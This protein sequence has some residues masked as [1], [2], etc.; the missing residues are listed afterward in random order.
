MNPE[1]FSTQVVGIF[2]DAQSLAIRY[3]NAEITDLHLTLAILRTNGLPLFDILLELGVDLKEYEDKIIE[4]IKKLRSSKG[5]TKL[6]YSRSYQRIIINSEEISRNLYESFVNVNS[7]YLA[8][9]REDKTVSQSIANSFSIDYEK[10]RSIFVEEFTKEKAGAISLENMKY[11]LKFGR[12]LTKEASEGKI[13]PIIGRDEETTNVIRVLSRRIKNNPV[14]IGEAGVGKTAVVEGLVKRIASKDVPEALRDKIVFSLDMTSI[15]AGAKFR[16]DFEERLKKVLDIVKASNTKIIL[17]IDEIHNI[18]GSGTSGAMDTSNIL[19][20]ML[21]RGEILTIGATTTRE[22]RKYIETD[23]A[24]ERRFQKILIDEP[25]EE[26]AISILRGIKKKYESFHKLTIKDSAIVAAVKLSKRYIN[27][28][29]LPDK[30]I[31][32]VDEASSMVRMEIDSIPSAIDDLNRDLIRLETEKIDLEIESDIRS[33]ERLTKIEKEIEEKKSLYEK[34]L[35]LWNKEL[36]RLDDISKE[37]YSIE[38]LSRNIEAAK[39]SH[40]FKKLK[41]FTVEYDTRKKHLEELLNIEPYYDIKSEV[42]EKEI[43]YVL[44]K[45]TG[46]SMTTLNKKESDKMKSLKNDI[47]QVFI[48]QENAVNEVVNAV[49]REKSGL[50]RRNK[51]ISY[52]LNGPRGTGK[53]YLP[54]VLAEKLYEDSKEVLTFEMSEYTDKS[55]VTKLIGAPPGYV[56]HELGGILTETVRT[57]PYSILVFEDIELC[58]REVL[59]IIYQIID[60]GVI[61]DNKGRTIDFKNTILFLTTRE[62]PSSEIS[63]HVDDILTFS[64][65]NLDELSKIFLLNLLEIESELKDQAIYLKYDLDVKGIIMLFGIRST[66]DIKRAIEEVLMTEIANLALNENIK[67][68]T[69]L[70]L[71]RDLTVEKVA[72]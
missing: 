39:E 63:S 62:T 48:G 11:L 30:A 52:L 43:L 19:K 3:E 40:D 59:G 28:R 32:L 8:I 7:L 69:I 60:E 61:R 18:I 41:Q 2:K 21:A 65:F 6:Y 38:L 12:N 58:D 46:I 51:P 1:K 13:D 25:T 68:G 10:M 49:I 23:S 17:F 72:P 26:G 15:L 24:L 29:Y 35:S 71:Q 4:A 47:S 67:E 64:E 37:S 31:D 36:E 55:S 9:L 57:K 27:D 54:Q 53:S 22:Y 42:T 44:S 66:K 14:L 50:F 45:T 16:G 70:K 34:K 5:L 33:R 20:P 56:G